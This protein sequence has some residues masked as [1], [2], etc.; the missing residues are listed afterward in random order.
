MEKRVATLRLLPPAPSGIEVTV[1]GDELYTRVGVIFPIS[2]RVGQL[3]CRT[4]EP[5][6]SSAQAGH[7]D[8]QLFSQGTQAAWQWAKQCDSVRWFT[9][10]KHAI[11]SS[12]CWQA[13]T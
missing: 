11:L 1:E 13:N 6:V 7:K 5:L 3:L 4:S 8:V 9:D 10:G 12:G 2:P